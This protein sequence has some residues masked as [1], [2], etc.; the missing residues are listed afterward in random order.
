[1]YLWASFNTHPWYHWRGIGNRNWHLL[2]VIG[3]ERWYYLASLEYGCDAVFAISYWSG[4][5]ASVSATMCYDGYGAP[6]IVPNSYYLIE[7]T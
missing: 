1:M 4:Y 2:A 5:R 7:Y 3:G 6:Y